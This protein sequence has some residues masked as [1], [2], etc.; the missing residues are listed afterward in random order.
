MTLT[1]DE[2]TEVLD[3]LLADGENE[4]VE[5][6]EAAHRFS[7]NNTDEYT[8][9]EQVPLGCRN[10]VPVSAMT[11]LNHGGSLRKWELNWS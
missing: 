8:L 4:V 6:K 9:S 2:L 5:F 3:R 11:D 10:P 7:A 1:N